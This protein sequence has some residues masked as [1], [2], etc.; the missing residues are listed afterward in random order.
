M[1]GWIFTIGMFAFCF[2]ISTWKTTAP[3]KERYDD[4]SY[5]GGFEGIGYQKKVDVL[6]YSDKIIVK[7]DLDWHKEILLSDIEDCTIQ[8]ET[9]L[10]ERVSMGKLLC[11]G[12]FAFGMK[13]KQQAIAQDYTVVRFKDGDKVSDLVLYNSS[14]NLNKHLYD[15]IKESINTMNNKNLKTA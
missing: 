10:K 15:S 5:Y 9:Q 2:W 8:T 1:I 11:F 4:V 14:N 3:Y 13:G 12:V 7:K 6:I